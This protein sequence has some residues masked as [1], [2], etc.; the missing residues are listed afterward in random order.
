MIRIL[1][2][3]DSL[4][5]AM[6]LKS[7]LDAETDM[8]VVGH[9]KDGREGVKMALELKP[10][11]IT[12]D[13]RMPN[14]DGFEATREIMAT[15]PVPIVVVSSSVDDEELKITFHAIGAGALAVLEKPCGPSHPDYAAVRENLLSTLRAMSV[16]KVVRRERRIRRKLEN[17]ELAAAQI[18]SG[19]LP[20]SLPKSNGGPFELVAIGC[21]TGGPQALCE[22]FQ[23][24]PAGFP[25]PILVVQ[26]ISKGFISGL[27]S[28]LDSISPLHVKIAEEGEKLLPGKVYLAP[29]DRH[30]LA[31][32]ING[33]L[34]ATLSNAP[35]VGQFR[36]SAT[37][38]LQSVSKHCGSKAI[39]VMLSGMGH[40]GAAGMKDLHE[41]QG[42]TLI[43]DE[44]SC[45][46]F[47]MPG[48]ALKLG[49]VDMVVN[50]SEI[51]AYLTKVMKR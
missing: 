38:L 4:V 21:S 40:D 45:V 36:P 8:E 11:L 35:A 43:Q 18:Y 15:Q 50:L 37:P 9:A 29:D 31:G 33:Q 51:G 23:S 32:Q 6:L 13:I 16:V 20:A 25:V 42:H 19:A 3:E 28:W 5:V 22:V 24:L 34:I 2:V 47:G 48:S 12:M 39:G 14:M 41:A 7:M 44:E 46:V 17:G 49:A 1:I 30:L 10:D 27:V 26:H